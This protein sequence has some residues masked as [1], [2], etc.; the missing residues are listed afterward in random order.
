MIHP[1]KSKDNQIGKSSNALSFWV[2]PKTSITGSSIKSFSIKELQPHRG[3]LPAPSSTKQ[4]I[5]P[6]A[7]N[8]AAKGNLTQEARL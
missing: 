7:R 4:I 8:K 2:T 5:Y 6:L 1:Q 3:V